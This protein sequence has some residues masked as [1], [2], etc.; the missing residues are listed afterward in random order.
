M[1]AEQVLF[2]ISKEGWAAETLSIEFNCRLPLLLPVL[3]PFALKSCLV[4]RCQAMEKAARSLLA[5]APSS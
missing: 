3:P 1:T 4:Y 2:G 5:L